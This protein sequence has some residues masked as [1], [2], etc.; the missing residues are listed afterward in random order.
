MSNSTEQRFL[1]TEERLRKIEAEGISTGIY[2]R[3]Q[4]NGKWD[5]YDIAA[6]EA[7]SLLAWL[8]SR[9]GHNPW[10]ENCVLL[11]LGHNPIA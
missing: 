7:N 6:L 1:V 5:S 11:M 4:F 2:V 10:A 3:A 8:R 9:G